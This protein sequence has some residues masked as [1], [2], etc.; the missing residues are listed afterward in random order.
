MKVE[1]GSQGEE[2]SSSSLR[3][4][5]GRRMTTVT[6]VIEPLPLYSRWYMLSSGSGGDV[7]WCGVVLWWRSVVTYPGG[8]SCGLPAAGLCSGAGLWSGVVLT[9]PPQTHSLL[10]GPGLPHHIWHEPLA[11]HAIM[12]RTFCRLSKLLQNALLPGLCHIW[13]L[14]KL[15]CIDHEGNWTHCLENKHFWGTNGEHFPFFICDSYNGSKIAFTSTLCL[16][17][18]RSSQWDSR[19]PLEQKGWW[20]GSVLL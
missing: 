15:F 7:P 10:P 8:A 20:T 12:T 11:V 5:E 13:R 4:G 2:S 19:L 18:L 14:D 17:S 9:H 3:T 16:L 6:T 1:N